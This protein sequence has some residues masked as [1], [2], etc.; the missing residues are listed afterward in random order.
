VLKAYAEFIYQKAPEPA[1]W[2]HFGL[3][4]VFVDSSRLLYATCIPAAALFL[5]GVLTYRGLGFKAFPWS[6][7][8]VDH[9]V[10]WAVWQGDSEQ[11]V[12]VTAVTWLLLSLGLRASS[13]VYKQYKPGTL[14]SALSGAQE[15]IID[16]AH[17]A[18]Y[19][20]LCIVLCGISYGAWIVA[21]LLSVE[22]LLNPATWTRI[23]NQE[24]INSLAVNSGIFITSTILYLHT[25][26]LWLMLLME[27]ILR[28]L[29][30]RVFAALK[31]L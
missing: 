18:F 10:T 3:N 22:L 19:R 2:W 14:V 20:E 4:P 17:W 1:K 6:S 31:R 28:L 16:Q 11:T 9:Q 8:A 12:W 5:Q 13:V 21:V 30:A 24:G 27:F 7:A 26:N 25:Q 23:K 15:T 29:F